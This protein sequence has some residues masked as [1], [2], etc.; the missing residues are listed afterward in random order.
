MQSGK[1]GFL[2]NV[3]HKAT[4]NVNISLRFSY[5]VLHFCREAEMGLAEQECNHSNRGTSPPPRV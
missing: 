5:E 1:G 3:L 2:N 4:D